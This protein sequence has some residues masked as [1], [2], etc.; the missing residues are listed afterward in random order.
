MRIRPAN[1]SDV[2]A[3]GGLVQRAYGPYVARIG[4]RPAPMDADYREKVNQ[5]DVFVA[6]DTEIVGVVVLIAM[7]D[8]VLIENVAVEADR[9]GEGIGKALLA[10]AEAHATKAG[11]PMLRLYTN[12]AMTENLALYSRLGYHEVGRRTEN[13]FERVFLSKGLAPTTGDSKEPH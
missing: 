1:F 11:K 13:G 12:A 2:D 3:I 4:L 5:A 7:P 8:H 10:F 9:R 6:V